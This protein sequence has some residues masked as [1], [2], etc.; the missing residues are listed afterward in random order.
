IRRRAAVGACRRRPRAHP[1]RHQS[2][3]RRG[4][5][6]RQ[7]DRRVDGSLG[8]PRREPRD[9]GSSASVTAREAGC[10]RGRA[11]GL[12]APTTPMSEGY[13][14]IDPQTIAKHFD[15]E[16][17]QQRWGEAWEARGI[18]HYDPARPRHETFVVD[19]P[20]PTVSGAL[21]VGHVFS[22][23]HTDVIVRQRRTLVQNIFYP[24]GS[25][26]NGLP[27]ERHVHSHFHVRCDPSLP[28]TPDLVLEPASPKTRKQPPR[29]LS[30]PNFIELRERLTAEDEQA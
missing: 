21:H 16:H 12:L 17:A 8:L 20:P 29:L 3:T 14:T 24:M 18:Y 23:T 10:R 6:R 2:R 27:T 26:D 4:Q 22:Y 9:R 28:Y 25:C 11:C 30:H 13:R 7:A 1:H 19:T 5:A 15:A